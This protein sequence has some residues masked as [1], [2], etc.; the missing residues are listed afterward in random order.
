MQAIIC[1]E[2]VILN[3]GA[4]LRIDYCNRII[5][6]HMSFTVGCFRKEILSSMRKRGVTHI[7]QQGCK[8]DELSV[9]SQAILV[10]GQIR[11]EYL[12]RFPTNCVIQQSGY[13]HH[14]KG[15]LEPSVHRAWINVICPS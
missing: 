6:V 13:V 5:L 3:R 4:E 8:A 15:M 11:P 12:A 14:S 2:I 9:P 10:V 1:I 7:M